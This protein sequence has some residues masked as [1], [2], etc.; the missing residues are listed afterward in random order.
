VL[1]SLKA[2]HSLHNPVATVELS[3]D[4]KKEM[5][6]VIAGD[7]YTLSA[8]R[9]NHLLLRLDSFLSDGGA[10]YD[11]SLLTIEH[12]LP[13]TVSSESQWAEQWPESGVREQWLHRLANL[14]PLNRKRN[15]AAQNY[16]FDTKK[17][18]YF[19]GRQGVSSYVLTTQVLN[20]P[21]W[22]PEVVSTRQE[23]LIGVL[24]EKWEL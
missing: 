4:E 6:S 24:T 15:S 17:Q 12:V 22:T 19:A 2:D 8:R 5:L 23:M 13:Q 3:D 20:T 18:A 21:K 9:R 7:I 11:P 1:G 14:V 16:D 10:I